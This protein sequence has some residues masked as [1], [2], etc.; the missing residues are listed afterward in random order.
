MALT[1]TLP[2]RRS[3]PPK[4]S[5]KVLQGGKRRP[6]VAFYTKVMDQK[7]FVLVARLAAELR[8][9]AADLA[10]TVGLPK[11]AVSKSA[12]QVSEKT[13]MRLRELA[14]IINHAASFAGSFPAALA[15][16]RSQPIPGFGER[17]AEAM[18]KEGYAEAVRQYLDHV[19]LGGFA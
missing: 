5:A 12:R 18:V 3:L 11:E 8:T 1:T 16:Y 9:T 4:A 19:A 6:A 13:Q 14:E 10:I 17:T 2:K 15:W 7:G